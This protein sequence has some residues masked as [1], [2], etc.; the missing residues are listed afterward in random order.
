MSYCVICLAI[1]IYRL[2]KNKLILP[3]GNAISTSL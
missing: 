2:G 3:G 1:G